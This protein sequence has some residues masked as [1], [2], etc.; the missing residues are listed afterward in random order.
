MADSV[1][2]KLLLTRQ[3]SAAMLS[4]SLRT[5]DTLLARKDL[6]T[7]RVGRRRLIP[8]SELER[9]AR[10]DHQTKP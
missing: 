8:R 7:R 2:S 3:E 9:F 10:R 4:I 5:L 6:V 1:E